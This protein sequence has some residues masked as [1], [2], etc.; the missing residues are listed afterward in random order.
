MTKILTPQCDAHSGVEFFELCDRMSRQNRNRIR[1]YFS[2][3]NR[4]LDGFESW[5]KMEVKIS[6]HTPF[7]MFIPER[8]VGLVRISAVQF[9][10]IWL[11]IAAAIFFL[12]AFRRVAAGAD[13]AVWLIQNVLM[14]I[15]IPLFMLMRI[16]IQLFM[17]MR[18]RF[19]VREKK[20]FLPNL[21]LFFPKSYV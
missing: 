7:N 16:L 18:I 14:R 9:Y 11:G 15:L 8:L 10:S 13:K 20:K 12:A 21:H 1:K 17:R 3:F 19:A 6:W 2:L 5:T 4:G